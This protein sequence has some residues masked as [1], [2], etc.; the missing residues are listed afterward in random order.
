MK[1]RPY[2]LTQ[3]DKEERRTSN[4]DDIISRNIKK[5]AAVKYPKCR[6][7]FTFTRFAR[8]L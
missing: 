5:K 2:G 1:L 3:E 6:D 8:I 4:I 7:E